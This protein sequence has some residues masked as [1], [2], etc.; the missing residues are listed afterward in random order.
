MEEF[1]NQSKWVSVEERLPEIEKVGKNQDSYYVLC[2]ESVASV[3]FVAWYSH[4]KHRWTVSHHFA[5]SES[6]IVN[7]W[8]HL[9]S[10]PNQQ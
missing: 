6:A 7:Y 8:Q 2:A 5:T 9:P 1:A 3:P 10:P 4:S